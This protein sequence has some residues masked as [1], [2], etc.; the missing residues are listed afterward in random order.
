MATSVVPALLDAIRTAA[1]T[2]LPNVLVMDGKGVTEDPGDY[3]MVGIQDPEAD[4]PVAATTSE[5]QQAFGSTKPRRESG[6]VYLTAESWNGDGDMK[7]ARDAVYAIA[8][9]LAD[10]LRPDNLAVPGLHTAGYGESTTFRQGPTEY[11]VA[12]Q[13]MLSV[14]FSAFI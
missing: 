10:A 1:T 12:A 9:A 14:D 7:A 6:S 2:A 8:A 4:V 3:L 5:A 11:G 13:L